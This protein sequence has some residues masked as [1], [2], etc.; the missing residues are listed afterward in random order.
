VLQP[1]AK[2]YLNLDA[3]AD[4]KNKPNKS[5]HTNPLPAE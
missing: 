4:Y 3:R 5:A 2:L 1:R